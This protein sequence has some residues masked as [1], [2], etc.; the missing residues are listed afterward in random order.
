MN[1]SNQDGSD[2]PRN[3]LLGNSLDYAFMDRKKFQIDLRQNETEKKPEE[4][5]EDPPEEEVEGVQE[6]ENQVRTSTTNSQDTDGEDS[7]NYG[8]NSEYESESVKKETITID[9]PKTEKKGTKGN[10]PGGESTE[11]NKP[12]PPKEERP[13]EG[14]QSEQDDG[15]KNKE[16]KTE[17]DNEKKEEGELDKPDR[18]KDNNGGVT[19]T[20][21]T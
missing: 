9:E 8:N 18:D 2:N 10:K 21:R 13:T 14:G 15:Q 1:D 5:T 16:D 20:P 6:K 11:T 4:T 7:R 17:D 3:I 19:F 12:S